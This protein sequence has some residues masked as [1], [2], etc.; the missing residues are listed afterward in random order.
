MS[1][2]MHL[3]LPHVAPVACS[4][5]ASQ[6]I[7]P[8]TELDQLDRHTERR[9]WGAIAIDRFYRSPALR[10]IANERAEAREVG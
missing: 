10:C 2:A 5:R 8:S 6:P 4:V 7:L 1:P 9:C 3:I